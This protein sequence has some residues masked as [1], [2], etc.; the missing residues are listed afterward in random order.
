MGLRSDLDFIFVLPNQPEDNDF[1]LARRLVTRLTESHRG[2]SIY[3]I[4]MRLRPSGKAGPLVMIQDE[5]EKYLTLEAAAWERQAYL[6]A[7]WLGENQIALQNCFIHKGLSTEDLVELNRIRLQLLVPDQFNL[8]FSEGGLVDIELAAQTVCLQQKILPKSAHTIEI[9]HS[10]G[11]EYASMTIIYERLRHIE[12]MLQLIASE[13]LSQVLPNTESFQS[14][15]V[16]LQTSY[17]HLESELQS[18]FA[19]SCLLLKELD[20]RRASH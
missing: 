16:A 9:L 15:A 4:D 7:R 12:Q 11:S 19:D 6:K 3:S 13:S 20:P 18:L 1:K 17:S 5:L 10:L 14:L 2:G 8:K